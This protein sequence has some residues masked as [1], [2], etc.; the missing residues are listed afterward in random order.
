MEKRTIKEAPGYEIS[1]K[2]QVFNKT[3]GKPLVTIK[4]Q[5]YLKNAKGVRICRSVAK[6]HEIAFGVPEPKNMKEASRLYRDKKISVKEFNEYSEKFSSKKEENKEETSVR[7]PRFQGSRVL[8]KEEE[9]IRDLKT[10]KHYK[11]YLLSKRGWTNR[12]IADLLG[13]NPGNV[14]NELKVYES[15]PERAKKMESKLKTI[16][17]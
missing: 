14:Y 5:V 15:N 9:E 13:P 12:E 2:Q 8:T 7:A 1:D 16:A 4:G 11:Y 6:L 17:E 10:K 3:T